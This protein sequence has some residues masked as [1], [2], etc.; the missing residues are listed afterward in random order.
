MDNSG[1]NS[2]YLL[3]SSL[4]INYNR[5][6][7]TLSNLMSDIIKVIIAVILSSMSLFLVASSLSNTTGGYENFVKGVDSIP[8][9]RYLRAKVI[10]NDD[11]E[12]TVYMA[13]TN[14]QQVK[15]LSV[16]DHLKENEGMVFVY[17][18]PTR[19]TFW[20]K[21]MKFPIDIIWLDSNG[22]VVHIE[23]NLQP[24]I[25]TFAFMC[26]SYIPDDDSL[27]VLETVAGFSKKHGI[28]VGTNVDFQLIR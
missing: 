4:S 12:L 15:G 11:F 20:M 3:N 28:K 14:D 2:S 1:S 5:N 8:N 9:D 24:C 16:R 10:V 18:Q 22:T 23:H 27:Y 25:M 13:V 7:K 6:L 19:Q 26:P 21:D 17:E